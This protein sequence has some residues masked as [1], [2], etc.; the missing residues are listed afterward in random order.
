MKILTTIVK[1]IST[2]I[3]V[4]FCTAAITAILAIIMPDNVQKAIEM[5]TRLI[6]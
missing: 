5:I 2:M 1:T 4:A 3:L 6:S